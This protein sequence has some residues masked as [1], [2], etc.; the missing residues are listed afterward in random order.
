MLLTSV[1]MEIL[2]DRIVSNLFVL[3]CVTQTAKIAEYREGKLKQLLGL[4]EK[5]FKEH[6]GKEGFVV[7]NKA[8]ATHFT[9]LRFPSPFACFC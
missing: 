3:Q 9:S 1:D 5:Y 4:F 6:V 2:F 8:C 7:G